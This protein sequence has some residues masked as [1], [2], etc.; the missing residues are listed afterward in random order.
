MFLKVVSGFI[1][2]PL[3]RFRVYLVNDRCH[4]PILVKKLGLALCYRILEQS[5]RLLY[6]IS[7]PR[8]TIAFT[9]CN[10]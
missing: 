7:Y 1:F 9:P 10:R 3:K 8:K 4:I 6:L 5:D 2:I